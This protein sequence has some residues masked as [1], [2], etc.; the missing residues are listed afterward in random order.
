M[1][2]RLLLLAAAVHLLNNGDI[3]F[4]LFRAR[5]DAQ[6]ELARRGVGGSQKRGFHEESP[7]VFVSDDQVLDYYFLTPYYPSRM[8]CFL[9]IP[10]RILTSA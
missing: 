9:T 8:Y 3:Q 6:N 4:Q 10:L 5:N 2:L 1:K 7:S